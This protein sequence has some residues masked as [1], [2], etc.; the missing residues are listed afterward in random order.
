[1][2][3]VALAA[4]AKLNL[5]LRI[6]GRRDDGYH[7]LE[8]LFVPLE[9]ADDVGIETAGDA[10]GVVLEVESGAP[11][12]P[13]DERNLAVRAARAFL[14]AS[15]SA[16][17]SV[18]IRL[19][20]RIPVAAGLG[21]GSSDAAA[22]L[23]GLAELVPAGPQG[24]ALAEV[25]LTIGADVPFFLDPRPALVGGIGDRI[26]L[27]DGLRPLWAVL[28]N[29]GLEV[30]TAEVFRLYD[31]L[32]GVP[33]GL[34]PHDPRSTM[35]AVSEPQAL[36]GPQALFGSGGDLEVLARLPG[37]S[38]DL[39]AAAIRLCPAV[40][41]LRDRMCAQGA[42]VAGM[43]GSGATVYGVFETEV[44]AQNALGGAGFESPI[45]TCVTKFLT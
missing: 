36:A 1:V 7:R 19:R 11:G 8:S 41:R 13:S 40:A 34:T 33:G 6:V 15:G 42:L 30:S 35:P 16:E 39:E 12:V 21:G 28:A 37:L 18:R 44:D 32:G 45:W 27:L 2:P 43:S 3:S 31:A 23:R 20:K 38:N 26:E 14:E 4:P 29:P 22:V 10:P 17:V 24:P 25:A 9:L 5:G